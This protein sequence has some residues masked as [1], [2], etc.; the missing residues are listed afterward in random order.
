MLSCRRPRMHC[1][2]ALAAGLGMPTARL[3]AAIG[4]SKKKRKCTS[5]SIKSVL[6]CAVV[7]SDRAF[8]DSRL[9]LHFSVQND[10][11]RVYVKQRKPLQD[12]SG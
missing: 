11:V 7:Y 1:F 5:L 9:T 3:F 6:L 10:Y 4:S 2:G 12:L 8:P